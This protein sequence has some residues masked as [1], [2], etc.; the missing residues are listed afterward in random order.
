MHD[1]EV[2]LVSPGQESQDDAAQ[3]ITHE[4]R[5]TTTGIRWFLICF[6]IYSANFLYG[7]DATIAAD[8]QAPVAQTYGDVQKLGWLGFGFGLGSTAAILPLGKAYGVFDIKWVF[9]ASLTM[10]SASSA[11]C[12]AAPTMDA[13]IVGRVLAGSGG[14]GMYLG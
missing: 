10:F 4:T 14:A 5:R 9:I 2:G 6:A 13:L 7:L 1:K 8:I 3:P 11:L 12:G